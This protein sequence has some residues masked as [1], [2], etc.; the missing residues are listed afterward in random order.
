ML[1]YLQSL[2]LLFNER[3][4]LAQLR[5]VYVIKKTTMK[6]GKW[7]EGNKRKRNYYV[8]GYCHGK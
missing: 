1:F 4:L 5:K 3:R 2:T 8:F 7:A 6:S